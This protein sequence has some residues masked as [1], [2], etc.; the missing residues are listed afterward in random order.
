MMQGLYN[1]TLWFQTT[2]DDKMKE[3]KSSLYDGAKITQVKYLWKKWNCVPQGKMK[4]TGL[5]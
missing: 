4:Y 3:E 2:P 5:R 1:V